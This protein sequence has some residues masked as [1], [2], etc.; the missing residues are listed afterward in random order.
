MPRLS[1]LP[2]GGAGANGMDAPRSLIRTLVLWFDLEESGAPRAVAPVRSRQTGLPGGAPAAAAMTGAGVSTEVK[3]LHLDTGR[4]WRGGQKQVLFLTQGLEERGVVSVVAT[5]QDSP[6]ATRLRTLDLPMIPLPPGSPFTPKSVKMLQAVLADRHWHILHAHTAHAHTMGFISLRLPPRRSFHRPAVI[7]SRR[8][9]FVPSRDPLTRL[10][11]TT[12]GQTF[13]CVSDA[14]A[15]VLRTYGVPSQ[16]IRTV[17]SGVPI[18]GEPLPFEPLPFDHAPR[19]QEQERRD[20]RREIG[21]AEDAFVIGNIAQLVG[22]KGHRYLLDAMPTIA[23]AVPNARLLIFGAGE[24]E[25]DLKRQSERLGL[26]T[27][28]TFAG[29]RPDATRYLSAMD[30]FAISSVEE[31]LGTSILDAEAA[32]L[33]VVGTRAGGIP[34]TIV[35]GQTGLLVE[36]QDADALATAI[37][38]LA[39]DPA[40]RAAMGRAGREWVKERFSSAQMV[41]STLAIYREVLEEALPGPRRS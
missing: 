14:I 5:P 7:V 22:H 20:L 3:I 1:Y 25:G 15:G 36:P 35:D 19:R 23:A 21:M 27:R 10:K 12:Q 13:I 39:S 9:D 17:H 29:F 16:H 30:I 31:G 8:V 24:L 18:P 2:A 41:E 37:I 26:S 32:G 11:F 40:R 38:E 6:L 28:V 4:E 34:E 33:A